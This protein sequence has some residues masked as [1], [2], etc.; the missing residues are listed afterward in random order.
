MGKIYSISNWMNDNPVPL[1]NQGL[2]LTRLVQHLIWGSIRIDKGI[3][4]NTVI[5]NMQPGK[6]KKISQLC[7]WQNHSY[8]NIVPTCNFLWSYRNQ[9]ADILPDKLFCD[10]YPAEYLLR[11]KS[12]KLVKN[13]GFRSWN[14]N[15]SGM[16]PEWDATVCYSNKLDGFT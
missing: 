9:E 15:L 1:E 7:C 3:S 4:F 8:N 6:G 12:T 13:F 5:S 2:V 16:G 14:G 10:G 11:K